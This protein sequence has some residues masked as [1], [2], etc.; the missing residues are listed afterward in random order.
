MYVNDLIS[1]DRRKLRSEKK[2]FLFK[3]TNYDS[4]LFPK[5]LHTVLDYDDTLKINVEKSGNT[6]INIQRTSS[7]ASL[8]INKLYSQ[9]KTGSSMPA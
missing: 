6:V 9:L 8:C 7:T 5:L 4:S 1:D 3:K 2:T